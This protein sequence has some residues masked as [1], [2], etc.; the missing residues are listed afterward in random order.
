M[1][2]MWCLHIPVADQTPFPGWNINVTKQ[3]HIDPGE[4]LGECLALAV[5]ALNPDIDFVFILAKPSITNSYQSILHS[6]QLLN[7]LSKS[8]RIDVARKMFDKMTK[9]DEY[10]WNTMIS[11]YV[12]AGRLVEARELLNGFSSRSSITWSS[13]ISGYCRFGCK[14]EAFG[15]FRSMRLEGQK[16]SQYTLGSI[17]R[18]VFAMEKM[19]PEWISVLMSATMLAITAELSNVFGESGVDQ[20]VDI[21]KLEAMFILRAFL[22]CFMLFATSTSS[23]NFDDAENVEMEIVVSSTTLEFVDYFTG[24]NFPMQFTP[25]VS[26]RTQKPLLLS[27][28]HSYLDILAFAL[29]SFRMI[30]IATW[31]QSNLGLL[32]VSKRKKPLKSAVQLIGDGAR[33]CDGYGIVL[34]MISDY[35]SSATAHSIVLAAM[36]MLVEDDSE[37][38]PTGATDDAEAGASVNDTNNWQLPCGEKIVI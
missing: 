21:I 2:D 15:L 10:S 4:Y 11:G 12:N 8:G 25:V 24:C 7:G 37:A 34:V 38:E 33:P 18:G 36:P 16:P 30:Q 20:L 1:F 3:A 5:A 6:N 28:F 17:L 13:L 35:G 32:C 27:Q 29:V 26:S 19:F 31:K 22:N 23:R 9:R 14:D